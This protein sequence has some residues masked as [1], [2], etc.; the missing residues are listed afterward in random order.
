MSE[1]VLE[2][3]EIMWGKVSNEK[4]KIIC[5]IYKHLHAASSCAAARGWLVI[6]ATWAECSVPCHSIWLPA[7]ARTSCLCGTPGFWRPGRR[8]VPDCL[9]PW[10]SAAA[11]EGDGC[12]L[13][14][15]ASLRWTLTW[16]AA[17]PPPCSPWPLAG[18]ARVRWQAEW[19]RGRW[20][21]ADPWP[22]SGTPGRSS[23]FSS[24]G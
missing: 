8:I 9:F 3:T 16:A 17:P 12:L 11:G 15:V 7:G 18:A 13:T 19:V 6:S 4:K 1:T 14:C 20:Q 2:I 21:E 22:A 10:G 23:A 24:P 5:L